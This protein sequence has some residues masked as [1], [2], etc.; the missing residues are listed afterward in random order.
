MTA[1][2]LGA[3]LVIKYWEPIKGFFLDLVSK[4]GR[5][6]EACGVDFNKMK[7]TFNKVVQAIGLAIQA[8]ISFFMSL[9]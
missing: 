6:L 1:I 8:L 9:W 3:G 5:Y 4:I 2:A 7:E